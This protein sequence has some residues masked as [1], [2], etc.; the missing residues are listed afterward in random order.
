METKYCKSCNLT[1]DKSNFYT[2]G[3]TPAGTVKLKPT[4]KICERKGNNSN[5]LTKINEILESLGK[6]CEC[7]IC[8]YDKH[9]QVLEFHHLDPKA[10]EMEISCMKHATKERLEKEISKCMLL[11][12]NCHR[13]AH[14]IP[15]NGY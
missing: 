7:E 15:N 12:A 10:K 5:Y 14:I 6:R 2:N 11:C 4:C 8:G 13:E 3:K 1:L 9:F